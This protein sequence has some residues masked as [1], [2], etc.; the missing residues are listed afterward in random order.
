MPFTFNSISVCDRT[1]WLLFINR[2]NKDYPSQSQ[3]NN[4]S[5][6]MEPAAARASITFLQDAGLDVKVFV[7]D[8]SIP[9]AI[10]SQIA[11][12]CTFYKEKKI[13][14][15]DDHFQRSKSVR[16]ILAEEFPHILH[17]V[18]ATNILLWPH[19]PEYM[20]AD[21][22]THNFVKFDPWHFTHNMEKALWRA[23]KLKSCGKMIGS[24]WHFTE[25]TIPP[26]HPFIAFEYLSLY[27][28][29]HLSIQHSNFVPYQRCGTGQ[30]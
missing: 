2:Q 26:I 1:S 19:I 29:S 14:R 16:A 21:C 13:V 7:T 17:Q 8:R 12:G 11:V 30:S 18:Q 4:S 20:Q 15:T 24:F 23:E 10:T 9:L 3:V 25:I 6:N 27:I 28:Q 5:P 22:N